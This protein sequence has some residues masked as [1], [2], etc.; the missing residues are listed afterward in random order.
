[1]EDYETR[2]EKLGL[3]SKEDIKTILADHN[4]NIMFLDVRNEK[5]VADQPFFDLPKSS[6]K[7]VLHH[8]PCTRDDA[9][10]LQSKVDDI[11]PDKTG[12]IAFIE[13]IIMNMKIYSI[14]LHSFSFGSY[15]LYLFHL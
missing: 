7:V 8:V 13:I 12:T 10:L 6:N 9:T 1:M 2:Q 5:E 3:S 15:I 14:F 4:E 11:L